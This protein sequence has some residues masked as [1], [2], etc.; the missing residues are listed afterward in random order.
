MARLVVHP[1]LGQA[2]NIYRFLSHIGEA[3]KL[4]FS[5]NNLVVMKFS[6]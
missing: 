5:V 2:P 6:Y 3:L 1:I 4:S